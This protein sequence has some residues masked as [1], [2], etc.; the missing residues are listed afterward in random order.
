MKDGEARRA[1]LSLLARGLITVAEATALAG[2]SRQ[3]MRAWAGKRLK[4]YRG[5]RRAVIAKAWRKELMNGA[6]LVERQ[7]PDAGSTRKG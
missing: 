1:A 4:R 2:V 6:K 3:L 5:T 7:K